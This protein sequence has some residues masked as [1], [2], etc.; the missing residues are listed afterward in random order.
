MEK[1][2]LNVLRHL[3]HIVTKDREVLEASY[4]FKDMTGYTGTDILNKDIKE[5]FEIL[6][7][8]TNVD[9][10]D[11]QTEENFFLFTKFHDVRQI[12]I[13]VQ[14][15]LTKSEKIYIFIE[16]PNSRF[17]DMCTLVQQLYFDNVIGIAIFNT[18]DLILLKANQ[19]CLNFMDEPY[20]QIQNII[21]L[22]LEEYT[23][24]WKG[25]QAEEIWRNAVKTGKTSNIKE[26]IQYRH[27]GEEA[28]WDITL[29]PFLEKGKVKYITA[30]FY[31]VTNRVMDRKRME[32]QAEIISRQKEQLEVIMENM[33]DALY[34]LDK[35]GKFM[36]LNKTARSFFY[37]PD[38]IGTAENAYNSS[39]HYDMAGNEI[40]L[41]DMPASRV[42]RGENVT[43]SRMAIKRPDRDIYVEVNGEPIYDA[44]GNLSMIILC[45]RDVT[46][47]VKYEELL[48][49]Q[50]DHLYKILDT[51]EL[52]ILGF[53]YPGLNIKE[54]NK[55]A[56]QDIC[57]V[58]GWDSQKPDLIK[59]GDNFQNIM[60]ALNTPE[61]QKYILEIE[62]TK[63]IVHRKEFGITRNGEKAY[64]NLVYHPIL[65]SL[66]EIEEI[67]I[68]GIDIT[69][70]IEQKEL[71]EKNLNIQNEFFS[72]ISHEFKTPLTVINS[73]IQAMELICKNELSKKTKGFISK[74]RQNTFRQL[75]LV[76]NLLDITKAEAGYIK[77]HKRNMDIVFLT[78]AITESVSIYAKE[79]GIDLKF[80]S[81]LEKSI[82]G[83]DDEK[84][85][86]ILLNLLSNAIKFTPGGKS[87]YVRILSRKH[88][89]CVD[90]KDEGVGIPKDKQHI[91]FDRFAQVDSSLTRKTEGT[92]IGLYLVKLLVNALD[93]EITVD[94]TE[95]KES[96][97]TILLPA[98]KIPENEG[99][100]ALQEITDNRLIQATAIEF[101]D[102]YLK[103]Y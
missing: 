38:Y 37:S 43:Q 33:S 40:P 52:P 66:G 16:K 58:M 45:S 19:Q 76:N 39:G 34:I 89:V 3:P 73:A 98:S 49:S 50:R 74:I 70:E 64:Y 8:N 27:N 20:N 87:I 101:S 7:I 46:E 91:I 1:E 5:V 51:L 59:P 71:V 29:I 10:E 4:A 94:S 81:L 69:H 75:R 84:Y 78:K 26:F 24:G 11:I 93:G 25:S 55:R 42:M 63:S 88:K 67:L 79:K 103:I 90:V 100:N 30:L 56:Y 12:N 60:T 44:N 61:N 22:C 96:T 85:E 28:Y 23:N 36:K 62:K 83:I 17:E 18:P 65:N 77:I 31:D 21:G 86:R 99:E 53:T 9:L 72:F 41:E 35:D 2:I 68:I 13:L 47:K 80:S 6:K 14:Q 82:I 57:E 102:I 15:G 54:F 48:K 95:G 97:F 32:E 92:G